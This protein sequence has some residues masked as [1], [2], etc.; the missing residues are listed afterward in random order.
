MTW[1][2]GAWTA[3]HRLPVGASARVPVGQQVRAGESLASGTVYGV[4]VRVA[5]ARRLGLAAN[6]L[7]RV[8]RVSVGAEVARGSV[9]ARTGRRFARAVTAPI[10]GRIAHVR[11]DGDIDV[12]PVVDHWVVRSTL[13]G[14]VVASNDVAIVVE[15]SAW[16]LQ[17]LAAYGP[18]AV[19]ELALGVE[20][21]A[22][23]ILPS[24]VD[25]TQRDR[26]IVAGARSGAEAIA[27]AHACGVSA[28]VAAAVPAAGLRA[29]FGDGVTA[30]GAPTSS[31][32]PTVLC[33][34]GFGSAQ[35]P[36]SVF[37]PFRTLVATRAAIHTATA[38]L[39]VFA[40]A[41]AL[42]AGAAPALAL[43]AEWGAI[44][45]L[46]GLV[47]LTDET[48]FESE[49]AMVAAGTDDGPIPAANVIALGADR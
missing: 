36:A 25:V 40:P 35:L 8:L 31:D 14:T 19:G 33:L 29:V 7:A 41:T 1:R 11:G 13:D 5:G 28:L 9:I 21:A 45:T 44:R 23:E 39:F 34:L 15:G 3:S 26:I 18:D 4:P 20:S 24:R 38:R 43:V 32:A 47:A 30:H 22:D 27:R 46:D 12:A 10:D 16:C 37:E 2:Y 42:A 6:D 48:S 49:R 17:G